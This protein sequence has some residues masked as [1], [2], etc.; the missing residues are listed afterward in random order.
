MVN[1]WVRRD[2]VDTV[3]AIK[4]PSVLGLIAG[5]G[6]SDIDGAAGVELFSTEQHEL[7]WKEG[8]GE[9]RRLTWKR[10]DEDKRA[11]KSLTDRRCRKTASDIMVNLFADDWK[12][13]CYLIDQI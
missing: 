12:T 6:W 10:C 5:W 9:R 7:S 11:M 8:L 1:N 3:D 13:F 2:S 4:L